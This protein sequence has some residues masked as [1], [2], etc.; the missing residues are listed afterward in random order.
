M[1]KKYFEKRKINKRV[2]IAQ[3]LCKK[4]VKQYSLSDDVVKFG[5]LKVKYYNKQQNTHKWSKKIK[6]EV[7]FNN[8][9]VLE[10]TPGYAWYVKVF[11]YGDW[12]R[13]LDTALDDL[14]SKK[15]QKYN[16]NFKD[17]EE[18]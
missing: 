17:L 9:L 15:D 11:H 2:K 12:V 18:Y 13:F 14:Q 6:L 7:W 1:F 10:A 16:L 5:W 4:Y 8:Q 3:A